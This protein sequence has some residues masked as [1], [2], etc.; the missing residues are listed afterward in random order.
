L[1]FLGP[2]RTLATQGSVNYSRAGIVRS[3]DLLTY[4]ANLRLSSSSAAA[5]VTVSASPQANGWLLC[6]YRCTQP[7]ADGVVA[8]N[9]N[10]NNN[11]NSN[12]NDNIDIYKADG[13]S[14]ELN[15]SLASADASLEMELLTA[16]E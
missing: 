3:T 4:L 14:T 13:M 7:V 10:N 1:A 2:N 12:S 9:S 6:I 11:N 15:L 5:A 8:Y 16:V